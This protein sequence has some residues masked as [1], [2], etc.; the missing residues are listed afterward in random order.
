VVFLHRTRHAEQPLES[1]LVDAAVSGLLRWARACAAQRIHVF[2]VE[3]APDGPTLA[4]LLRTGEPHLVQRA[5][6]WYAPRLVPV[7][8]APPH[9]SWRLDVTAKGLDS[10]TFVTCPE[11]RRHLRPGE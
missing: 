4:A 6:A 8:A 2:E 5:G 9:G 1:A 7:G 11:A 3:F 10:L